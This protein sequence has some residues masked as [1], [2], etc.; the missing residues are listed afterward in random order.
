MATQ[1]LI[2][3]SQQRCPDVIYTFLWT[4]AWTADEYQYNNLCFKDGKSPMKNIQ[5]P[6]VQDLTLWTTTSGEA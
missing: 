6:Q 3:H 1:S 4:F 5:T 2:L